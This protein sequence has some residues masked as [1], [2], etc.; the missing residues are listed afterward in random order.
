MEK[1]QVKV[2]ICMG[3]CVRSID[4]IYNIWQYNSRKGKNEVQNNQNWGSF[5]LKLKKEIRYF[6][7]F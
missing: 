3:N 2:S 6:H 4:I 1:N 5:R 7:Q